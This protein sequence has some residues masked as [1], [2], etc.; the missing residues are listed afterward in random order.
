MTDISINFYYVYTSSVFDKINFRIKEKN[1]V[2]KIENT[3]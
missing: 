3:L 2:Q 1:L